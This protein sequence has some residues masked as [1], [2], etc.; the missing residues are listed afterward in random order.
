MQQG[1]RSPALAAVLNFSLWG[2]GYIYVGEEFGK[3]LV[4]YD[5]ILA[6]SLA[7]IYIDSGY[8]SEIKGLFHGFGAFEWILTSS[9]FIISAIFAWHAYEMAKG[10][11]IQRVNV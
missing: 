5:M 10:M 4:I 8:I 2:L 11:N 9:L 7:L 6:F 3:A 1:K